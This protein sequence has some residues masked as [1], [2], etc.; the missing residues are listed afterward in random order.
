MKAI[1]CQAYGS[2]ESLVVE[3]IDVPMPAPDQVRVKVAAAGVNFVD[4]LFVAGSYQVKIPPPFIPGNELAGVI[5]AVGS[6]V[7]GFAPG[8]RVMAQVGVGA[9]AEQVCV[10]VAALR[11][12]PA[13]MSMEAAAAFQLTYATAL[14][15]LRERG[16]LQPG[17][18]VLVLA[19]AGGVGSAAVDVAKRLGARVIA[20][21]G[22]DEKLAHCREL[23][24]DAVIN[25]DR[26][27]LKTRVRELTGGRGADLVVDPVGGAYSEPAVRA[28]AWEGRFLVVGFAAGEIPRIP[29]NLTLLRGC[30]IVGVDWGALSRD[31]PA[32]TRPVLETLGEWAAAG[33]LSP[34]VTSTWPLAEAGR[35]LRAVLDRQVTGKAILLS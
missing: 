12:V 33:E 15:A 10:P 31:R 25:Y 8:D 24:A 4:A 13:G 2:P 35:A 26:E 20:A 9:F 3:E 27:D 29:L 28:T 23:G 17:E 7:E 1:T 22:T 30:Q 32:E 34:L 6:D 16:R 18:T 21:A 5:D 11:P 19:A 14:Y